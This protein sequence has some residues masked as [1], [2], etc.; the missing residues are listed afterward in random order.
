MTL[1]ELLVVTMIGVVVLSAALLLTEISGRASDRV[2]DRVEVVQRARSA[3]ETIVQQ[4]RSQVCLDGETPPIATGTGN[5]V[6]FYANLSSTPDYLPQRRTL[7][8]DPA[9]RTIVEQL[10]RTT[11]TAPPWT[12]GPTPSRTRTILTNVTALPD[13]PFLR[14]YSFD[15]S[16]P[17]AVPLSTNTTSNPL[18]ANSIAKV[19]RIDIA[20]QILPSDG[21]EEGARRS[22][23]R[24]SVYLRN[25]DYGDRNTTSGRTWGPR[26]D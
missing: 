11:S 1:P 21:N 12:F 18:V 2:T 6:T 17:L 22:S 5:S 16:T 19:V 23:F 8:Y 7:T 13:T 26:C 15:G 3:M 10:Y 24:T 9:S 14:Y 20:F 4:L 25:T